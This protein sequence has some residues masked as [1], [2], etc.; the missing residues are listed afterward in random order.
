MSGD[1]TEALVEALDRIADRLEAERDYLT[2][3]DSVIGDA[4]HGNNMA[5][6]TAAVVEKRDEL[7]GMALD[8]AVKTVG[9]T[10]VSEVG[11]A[12]GPLYGGSILAASA[13][14]EGGLTE[15]TAVAFAEAYLEKLTD[16]GD[17]RPGD[18]TM[19]DAVM[20]AVHTFQRAVEEDDLSG[21]DALARAVDAARRGVAYTVPLRASKGRASYLGL[22]SVGHR[23]PGATSTLFV[24]EE[25]LAT[26]E[27]HAGEAD[28]TDAYAAD[29][30]RRE[31]DEAVDG[32][33][34]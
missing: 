12:S 14:L 21:V 22:R 27:A 9:M 6:G 8:E 5:R 13:E 32:E 16:R 2:D 33:G 7:E 26:A 19:V 30:T 31:S 29:A 1:D 24:L 34:E 10:L 3:L 20:P 4:D 25:L 18:K 11:G 15:E 17:A 28:V 23:D